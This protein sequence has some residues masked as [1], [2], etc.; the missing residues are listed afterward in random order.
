MR[1]SRSVV[2]STAC[3]PLIG[4]GSRS[5]S[6]CGS[7]AVRLHVY[8]SEK[9][10]PTRTSSTI[11]RNRWSGD[12]WPATARRSGIVCGTRSSTARATSSTR[13]TSRVT[14]R[15]RHVGTVT[16]RSSATSKPK[17]VRIPRCSSSGTSRP[18][19]RLARSGRN[20]TTG[21]SGRPAW[22]STEPVS[23]APV[24]STSSLLASTAAGSAACGSTPFSHLFEPS[25][26]SASRSEVLSTPIGSKFAASSSTSVVSSATSDSR[27]PMIAASATAFSPSVISRSRGRSRRSMPS[28]VR[29]VSPSCARRT[30]IRPPASFARSN[31]CSGLP[32][33]CIT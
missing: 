26:R 4:S 11:R 6:G 29:S 14:S 10:A 2:R 28:S 24:R 27:P 30:T 23:S 21:R 32:H 13:S 9:P 8:A 33:T 31:A 22:T 1:P 20:A 5:A 17:P 7:L 16:C 3:S 25:V 12:R 15:A 18:I 19:R